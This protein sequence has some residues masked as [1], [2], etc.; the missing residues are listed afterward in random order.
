ME[1][2]TGARSF[3]PAERFKARLIGWAGYFAIAAIGWTIRWKSVG[4][5]TYESILKSGHRAIFAFWHGRIFPS[6]YYWRNRGIVVMTSQNLDGEGIAQCIQRLGYGVAR[7]SSSHG[8]FRALAQLA[9]DI[10][11]GKDAG[12]TIDGPRGPRYVAKQGPIL[13]AYKTGAAVFCFHVSMKHRIELKSWDGFQLPFP[14][15]EAV[16]LQGEPIW[17]PPDSSEDDLRALHGKMQETLDALRIRG[18]KW[19]SEPHPETSGKS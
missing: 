15:T 11:G 4:D 8:G 12:F 10:R 7:G 16:I 18:D 17:A 5:G 6:T 1:S 14:F 2:D 13:L 3:T 19:W 9:R